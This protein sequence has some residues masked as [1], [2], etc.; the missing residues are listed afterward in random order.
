MNIFNK[1][2]H[3]DVRKIDSEQEGWFG[4]SAFSNFSTKLH[5][6]GRMRKMY[7]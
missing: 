4:M 7:L 3:I 5:P 1:E 6:Q 2:A